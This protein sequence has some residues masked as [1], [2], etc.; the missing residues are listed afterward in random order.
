MSVTQPYRRTYRQFVD[1]GYVRGYILHPRYAVAPAQYIRAF[2]LL[3]KDMLDLF[4][5]VE[6]AD[7]NLP[8]YSFRIHELL[9]RA[10]VEVEAN[11]KAIMT[12]N[13][14]TGARK[15]VDK[16]NMNDYKLI[17]QSHRLSS[18][19]VRFPYWHGNCDIRRPFASWMRGGKP[20]WYD[21]YNST[22]H[23]R[24]ELFDQAT[25]EHMTDAVA[26]LLVILS[27]QFYTHDFSPGD[28]F[29]SIEPSAR[30][31]GMQSAIGGYFRI[32]FPNDWPVDQQYD[33]D[34]QVL[35][36]ESDPFQSFDYSAISAARKNRP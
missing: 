16:M 5:Y 28:M 14:Y 1:G 4:D 33:F 32:R 35:A 23:N 18:Y 20:P 30:N 24:Y 6:P 7:R 12:E 11:C 27:S 22:K 9:L 36:K 25:L 31:D 26:G 13:G 34:W 2:G 8:C 15:K 10:C 29:L 21:A 19:E 3:Q 17:E